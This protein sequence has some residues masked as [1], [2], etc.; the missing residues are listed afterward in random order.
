[1]YLPASPFIATPPKTSGLQ[2][3]VLRGVTGSS[4]IE[5]LQDT[6]THNAGVRKVLSVAQG[7]GVHRELHR[8]SGQKSQDGGGPDSLQWCPTGV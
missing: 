7:A 4:T 5:T 6:P 2:L 3:Y 8:T 1:M